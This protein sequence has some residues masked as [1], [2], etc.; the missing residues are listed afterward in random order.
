MREAKGD[1]HVAAAALGVRV[2]KVDAI[3][4]RDPQLTALWGSTDQAALT[5]DTAERR[6]QLENPVLDQL[7][8]NIRKENIA[9]MNEG[10]RKAG[11]SEGVLKKIEAVS[12]LGGPAF[13]VA[14]L[15]QSHRLMTV[16]NL[17][18]AEELD[19]IKTNYLRDD[20]LEPEVK[21]LWQ[22]AYN[23]IAKLVGD[24][25][26][27]NLRGT[28]VL[29]QIMAEREKRAAAAD[30]LKNAKPAFAPLVRKA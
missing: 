23:E 14:A 18:L 19:Y 21:A 1:K 9:L 25:Y 11:V 30:P 22:R 16:T 3:I 12:A 24:N 15:D 28:Q 2:E 7:A 27:R 26:D 8:E 13:I 6:R 10:L 17:E 5:P 29:A 20:G 4:G